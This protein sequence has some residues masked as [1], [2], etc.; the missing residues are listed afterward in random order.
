M[1][2]NFHQII[3]QNYDSLRLDI[4]SLSSFF[5]HIFYQPVLFNSFF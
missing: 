4:H 1:Y 3:V 5:Y 2:T